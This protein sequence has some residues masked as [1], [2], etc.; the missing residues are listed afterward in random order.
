LL[1]APP[2]TLSQRAD[3]RQALAALRRGEK[4]ATAAR[5]SHPAGS[6]YGASRRKQPEGPAL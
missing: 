3:A 1:G 6:R 4:G 5:P 2:V